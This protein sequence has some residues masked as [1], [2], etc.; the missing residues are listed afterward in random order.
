MS[1]CQGEQ[2]MSTGERYMKSD[3]DDGGHENYQ[4]LLR[5]RDR[6]RDLLAKTDGESRLKL[7]SKI[8]KVTNQISMLEKD[9]LGGRCLPHNGS[10]QP[11]QKADTLRKKLQETSAKLTMPSTATANLVHPSGLLY[12]GDAHS[13]EDEEWLVYS[14][15]RG[16][17]NLAAGEVKNHFSDR[18]S[19][20]SL[21]LI[22]ADKEDEP[23]TDLVSHFDAV[24]SFIDEFMARREV[25]LVHC[26][27]GKSRASTMIIAYLMKSEELTLREAFDIV[28]SARPQ[29]RPNNGF[30]RSLIR[31]E[32]IL[33]NK[34][35]M[36]EADYPPPILA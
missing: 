21:D 35:S 23:K 4:P 34:Q 17:V 18:L 10:D 15:A 12:I 36:S 24:Q 31:F 14:G 16:V 1:V 20:L 27:E 6:F 2:G 25:V 13:S 26:V 29:I 30:M 11:S 3:Q 8:D 33:Y 22:D 9:R 28:R 32:K 19:Y 5:K 7:I